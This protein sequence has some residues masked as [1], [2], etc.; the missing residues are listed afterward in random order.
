MNYT[1]AIQNLE[2][3]NMRRSSWQRN[4]CIFIVDKKYIKEW[5]KSYLLNKKHIKYRNNKWVFSIW[6][7][8]EEDKKAEDWEI[9]ENV[10]IYKNIFV[11]II[12]LWIFMYLVNSD[13]EIIEQTK[14]YLT[15]IID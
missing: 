2:Q 13:T 9:S 8:T 14:R 6:N 15:D 12:L 7:P 3:S 1:T 10:T 4:C 11:M 5:D